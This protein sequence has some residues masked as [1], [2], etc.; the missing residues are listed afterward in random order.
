[1]K[2]LLGNGA[3]VDAKTKVCVDRFIG[4]LCNQAQYDSSIPILS[5]NNIFRHKFIIS[6]NRGVHFII[7]FDFKYCFD[8][9][10]NVS[11][12]FL[13]FL[14]LSFHLPSSISYL[15]LGWCNSVNNSTGWRLHGYRQS[16][17]RCRGQH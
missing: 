9:I 1:M 7:I 3:K 6:S 11:L 13:S 5:K 17:V 2:A 4:I 10:Y 15:P 12:Y 14:L 16:P 8:S